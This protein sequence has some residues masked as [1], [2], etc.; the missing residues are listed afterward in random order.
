MFLRSVIS[1]VAALCVAGVFAQTA[2]ADDTPPAPPAHPFWVDPIFGGIQF[3]GHIEGGVSF[4][5]D[6]PKNNIS[7][8][9]AFTDRD[10]SFRINQ[11]MLNIEADLDPKN[12]GFQ[13]GFK[14]TGMYGTDSR[15]T[16][17]FNE[18]DR[19]TS[20]PYQWD[21]VEAAA[22]FHAPIPAT[23]G[24]D[25]TVGQYPTPLGFEVIDNSVNP[26]YSH[27]Y[28]FNY[29]LPFKH[30]GLYG[31]FHV[32]DMLDLWAGF[33]SGVNA[34]LGARGDDNNSGALLGGFGLNNLLG[35]N[36][37]ILGLAHIGA[38]NPTGSTVNG[39]AFNVNQAL[40][41]YFDGV[42]TYKINDSWTAVTE[43]N[44]V[45]DDAYKVTAG[46][47]AQYGIFRWNDQW[48]FTGRAEIF[49]DQ[50]KN[51]FTGFVCAFPG[52]EDAVDA[53]RN[54]VS[55]VAAKNPVGNQAY[56]GT[57]GTGTTGGAYNLTYG[58]LTMGAAYTPPLTMPGTL[59]VVIRPEARFDSIIGG[60]RQKPFNVGAAGIGTKTSQ[61]T[62]AID[63]ILSF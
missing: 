11:T 38:E 63:T 21:I 15:Y 31:T 47:V 27:S 51:G 10:N 62:L 61:V 17:F 48:S 28:I 37:T 59:G 41:E 42:V 33:D 29:G 1:F 43:L 32:T 9:Q 44:L 30:T 8:G 18:F 14:F 49:A 22:L 35:G 36:L 58:E 46:G 52:S 24:V 19:S 55:N 13:Y 56:C 5:P 7:F 20:S 50:A 34:D 23:G 4:N 60:G 16:H 54:I 40:R 2:R 3:S 26:L 53:Q 12:D 45:H 57:G 39:R 6:S 25:I